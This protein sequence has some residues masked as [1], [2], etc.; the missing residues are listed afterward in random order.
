MHPD[1]EKLALQIEKLDAWDIQMIMLLVDR[2][3]ENQ[4]SPLCLLNYCERHELGIPRGVKCY[5]HQNQLQS[6]VS[7]SGLQCD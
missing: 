3:V 7:S 4:S 2:L 1:I 6:K 5:E